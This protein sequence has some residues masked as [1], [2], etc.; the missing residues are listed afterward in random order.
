MQGSGGFGSGSLVQCKTMANNLQLTLFCSPTITWC[1]VTSHRG[2]I[3]CGSLL[4]QLSQKMENNPN[5]KENNLSLISDPHCCRSHGT[6]VSALIGCLQCLIQLFIP[7]TSSRSIL[8]A[9]N[10]H[11]AVRA[12]AHSTENGVF[13]RPERASTH[14]MIGFDSALRKH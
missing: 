7:H 3:S 12:A 10:T 1:H 9:R 13:S 5:C 14:A 4:R 6:P 8:I 11:A 2:K